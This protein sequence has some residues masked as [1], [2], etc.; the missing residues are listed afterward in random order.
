MPTPWSRLPGEQAVWY[1][2][3]TPS[4]AHTK[5]VY[6][7]LQAREGD[8]NFIFNRIFKGAVAPL[9]PLEGQLSQ[10]ESRDLAP[11]LGTQVPNGHPWLPL[12]GSLRAGG[13]RPATDR[14]GR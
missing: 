12:W 4:R 1:P 3:P 5:K 14:T 2:P 9:D 13:T 7:A 11:R 10:R 8:F 6:G